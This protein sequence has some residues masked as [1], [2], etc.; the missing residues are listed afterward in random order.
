[1]N[2]QNL[3]KVWDPITRIWHWL[4]VLA[5]SAGWYMGEFMSFETVM[6]HFYMGYT[7]IGLL[8]NQY[9]GAL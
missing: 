1:M 3:T 4:L 6:W 2:T 7:I 5:V 8:L 9:A